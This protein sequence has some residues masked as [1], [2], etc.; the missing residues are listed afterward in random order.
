[1]KRRVPLEVVGDAESAAPALDRALAAR[2]RLARV[3]VH[4]A[5]LSPKKRLAWT[6]NVMEGRSVDEVAALM[7]AGRAA[8]RSRIYWARRVLRQRMRKDP[9]LAEVIA[10]CDGREP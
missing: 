3:H 5:A 4:L 1:V 9:E 8:T 7:G 10:E 6:L 2:R